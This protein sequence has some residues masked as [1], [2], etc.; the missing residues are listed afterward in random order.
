MAKLPR[1]FQK[2]FGSGAGVDQ[3]SQFGSLF[4]GAPAF[5]TDP[6]AAQGLSNWLTG[7]FGAAIGGNAPA[8]E[9]MNSAMYV[10]TYQLAYLMQ[11]GLAEWDT[12]TTYYTGSLA[13]VAGTIYSSLTDAN[14]G[15]APASSPTQ[16][17]KL[18]GRTAPTIQKFLSGSGT[19]TTPANCLYLRVR[20]VG[21]GGGG[22]GS[23]S[24]GDGGTGG[25]TSFGTSLL[26]ANGGS[27]GA[28][29]GSASGSAGGTASLGTGPI[30]IAVRGG[31]GG[32][33]GYSLI[34]QGNAIGGIGGA[35]ALGGAGIGTVGSTAA[36]GAGVPNSGGG[37]GGGSTTAGATGLL[38]G[39]GAGS[40]GF[41]DA[42]IS[43]PDA[44]YAYAVGA[45][46]TAGVAGSG[47]AGGLGGSGMIEVTE[48]YQ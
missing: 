43:T 31:G 48:Y 21:G 23:Q 26:V 30:G 6:A 35:S 10:M 40:G 11:A 34:G 42:I 14:T 18:V 13:N 27:G 24:G 20:M 5:T 39:A 4:A 9:D 19:Y 32:A 36:G 37:A 7:W 8:I 41:V 29:G 44:T 33:P 38:G 16:W 47:N 46:G 28:G 17:V 12:S 15:N 2:I 25:T 1:V 3:I 22:G 45:G